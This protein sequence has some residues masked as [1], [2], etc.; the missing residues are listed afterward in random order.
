MTA[1]KPPAAPWRTWPAWV[2]WT[3]AFVATA[4]AAAGLGALSG[5]GWDNGLF[6]AGA[7]LILASTTQIRLGGSRRAVV[8][9]TR[10]GLPVKDDVPPDEREVEIRRGIGWFLM[11][12]GAWVLL[13][14]AWLIG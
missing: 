10:D 3:A 12:V 4:L 9:R 8:A 5:I 2:R 14:V 11:G 7:L 6:V 1:R 13:G